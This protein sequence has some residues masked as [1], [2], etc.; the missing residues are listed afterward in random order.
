MVKNPR[1][2]TV[3]DPSTKR[4]PMRTLIVALGVPNGMRYW[5]TMIVVEEPLS[6]WLSILLLPLFLLLVLCGL[7]PALNSE[8]TGLAPG[9]CQSPLIHPTVCLS[10]P[11]LPLVAT[12]VVGV[13]EVAAT[14]EVVVELR[15]PPMA[16]TPH[17]GGPDGALLLLLEATTL[18]RTVVQ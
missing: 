10:L 6:V 13:V 18:P 11:L 16:P 9:L 3:K 4:Q 7:R 8:A 5:P 17:P 1:R 12:P 14:E 15:V 2:K